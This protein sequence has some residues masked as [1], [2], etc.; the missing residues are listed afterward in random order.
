[1]DERAEW[2]SRRERG[3]MLGFRAALLVLRVLGRTVARALTAMIALYYTLGSR[4][5]RDVVRSFHQRLSGDTPGF[6]AIYRHVRT[7]AHVVLDRFLLVPRN[8][9]RFVITRNGNEHLEGLHA[10]HEGAL[11]VGAHLGGYDAMRMSATQEKFRLH[12]LGYFENARMVNSLLGELD[13]THSQQVMAIRPGDANQMLRVR[14]LIEA[15]DLVALAADRVG[16]NEKT[17]S[18]PFLGAPAPFPTGPWILASLLRCR[19]YLTFGIYRAPN[20]Y[21]LYCEPFADRIVLPRARRDE[22][23]REYVERY[24]ARLEEF[25]RRAPE[26]WFN[27]YDFWA[28]RPAEDAKRPDQSS[29]GSA[30]E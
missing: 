28:V 29:Q 25:A 20:R 9:K 8:A 24:A 12:I 19:V 16:L 6:G 5:V 10:R 18:V 26:N 17:I 2:L 15:G 4:R 11:L 3:T 1:M 22:A 23:L 21:E 13:P 27:F 14:E 7:F 30:I